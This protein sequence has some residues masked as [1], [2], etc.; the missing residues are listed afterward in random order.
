MKVSLPVLLSLN[1]GY[2]DT[3]GF[4][5]LRGLFTAHVT[6]NFVTFGAAVVQ[7]SSGAVAKLIALPVFCFVVIVT[8]LIG[9]WLEPRG[10]NVLRTM[11]AVKVVLLVMGAVLAIAL[12][13]FGDGDAIGAVLAGMCFVAGMAIQNAAH[14]IHFPSAPPTTLMTGT[15]T[16]IMIDLADYI[17]G[18]TPEQAP[19][20]R[21]RVARMSAAVGAFALGCGGAALMFYAAGKWCFAVVPVLGAITPFLGAPAPIVAKS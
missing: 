16:Q 3:A 10:A 21:A 7:G 20:V 18:L 15:T 12:G 1:A 9:R 4:L 2:L 11:L 19:A 5:A 13:P 8:R 17:H 6:G 14:R